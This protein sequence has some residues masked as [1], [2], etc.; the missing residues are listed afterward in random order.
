MFILNESFGLWQLYVKYELGHMCT[1]T[2][3]TEHW[4]MIIIFDNI[5]AHFWC[6]KANIGS[7][8]LLQCISGGRSICIK[9]SQRKK[10]QGVK[11][12][13]LAGQLTGPSRETIR[14]SN[15]FNEMIVFVRC[16]ARSTVLLKPNVSQVQSRKVPIKKNS[17][18]LR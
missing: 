4:T 2:G 14:F 16:V 11:S 5:L 10:S 6:Y 7:D 15:F 12:H 9:K 3:S 18:M 8:I 1:S 17:N 13:N